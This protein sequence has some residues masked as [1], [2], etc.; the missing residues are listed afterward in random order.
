MHKLVLLGAVLGR[1]LPLAFCPHEHTCAWER[2][3]ARGAPLRKPSTTELE[4][5][6]KDDS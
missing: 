1:R 2:L 5:W 6:F 3:D 4:W